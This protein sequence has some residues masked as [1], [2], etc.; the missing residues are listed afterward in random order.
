[1]KKIRIGIIS[2][3]EIAFRRFLPALKLHEKFEFAGVAYPMKD[4]WE[5]SNDE[6]INLEREKAV[7]IVDNFGGALFEGYQSLIECRDVDALYIP[8]P[9]ALHHYWA[10]LA[11]L[12][13]KHVLIEKPSTTCIADTE[14]LVMI[15]R[16]KNLALHENY[17]FQYHNQIKK[18]KELLSDGKIG[19]PNMFIGKFGFP[20]RTQNDFRYNKKLGGGSLLDCG[21]YPLKLISMLL[22]GDI[23]HVGSKLI[24]NQNDIDIFGS[25]LLSKDDILAQVSFG[26]DSSYKCY[27]EIWGSK[28]NLRADRIF[29]A[30]SGF[31]TTIEINTNEGK[32]EIK[33]LGD[34]SFLK[35][36]DYF[37]QCIIDGNKREYE[38]SNI[39]EQMRLVQ[40]IISN[41]IR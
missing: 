15:S 35:S 20:M 18:V 10:K 11:L 29:T 8:L 5:N 21:G 41:N 30:P 3:S 33:V 4:E 23:E 36:I 13:N 19:K 40:L 38:Y 25:A 24:Y 31:E 37:Y 12:N 34:D 2:P 6:I 17:M 1:M 14:E 9:P 26:M 27:L 16:E 7:N 39:L 28:G 32:E 22:G